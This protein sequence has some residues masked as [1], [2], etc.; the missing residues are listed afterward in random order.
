MLSGRP[1]EPADAAPAAVGARLRLLERLRQG[2]RTVH[3]VRGVK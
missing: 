2:P 1:A 3:F